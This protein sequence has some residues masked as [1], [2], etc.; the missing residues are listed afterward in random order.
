MDLKTSNLESNSCI[1][2]PNYL[3]KDDTSYINICLDKENNIQLKI[4]E[5]IPK[6]QTNQ[7]SKEILFKQ[8]IIFFH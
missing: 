5:I 2:V 1:S 4:N 7:F 6:T 3:S 8:K